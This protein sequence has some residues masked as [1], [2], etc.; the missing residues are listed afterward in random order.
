MG[1][2]EVHDK[3]KVPM[4]WLVLS[5]LW[6]HLVQPVNQGLQSIHELARKQQGFFQL[7]LPEKSM[8]TPLFLRILFLNSS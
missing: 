1:I 8:Q 5:Q 4:H 6:L 2:H 3:V 7:V